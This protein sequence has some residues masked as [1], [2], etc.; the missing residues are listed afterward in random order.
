MGARLDVS[1]VPMKHGGIHMLKCWFD[2]MLQEAEI[3]RAV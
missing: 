3:G 1:F 2:G